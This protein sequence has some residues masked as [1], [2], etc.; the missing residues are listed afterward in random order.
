MS[1]SGF[2]NRE[3][4]KKNINALKSFMKS[5]KLDSFYLSSS[6]I[7][8]NEYVPL[9]DCHRYYLTAFTGS[10]AEVIVPLEGKGHSICRWEIL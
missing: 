5:E 3:D 1:K 7:F 4:L 6:D 8:L 9:E 10:T 2:I